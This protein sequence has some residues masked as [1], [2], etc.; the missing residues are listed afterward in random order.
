MAK[1]LLQI[2][3]EM[4]YSKMTRE[5]E[6]DK[7]KKIDLVFFIEGLG[8][9]HKRKTHDKTWYC[10][11][12]VSCDIHASFCVFTDKNRFKCFSSNQGGSIIDF[13]MA[14]FNIE[15]AEALKM[16]RQKLYKKELK[17]WKK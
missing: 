3:T 16:L 11:P 6:I 7:I 15:Y 14:F 9:E 2:K 10:S 8:Y 5:N 17:K 4:S 1:K 13:T 12:L